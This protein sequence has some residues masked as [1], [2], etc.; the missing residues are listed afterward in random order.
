[1]NLDPPDHETIEGVGRAVRDG[2]RTFVDVVESCLARVEE[3]EPKVK[4]W[5]V[6]DRDRA[7]TQA[8][9]MDRELQWGRDRGAL[10]GIP[11][12]IK[13]IVDVAGLPTSAGARSWSD[14]PARADS[15]IVARLRQLGAVILGKTVT[16]AYA[17]VDPPPTRNPWD[18]GRTPGG[19]SSGSAAALACGMCLAA[20]GT[21]TGG[22]L[23]RPAAFCG[24]ASFKPTDGF[25]I[26]TGIVP[27]APSLDTPGFLARTVRDLERIWGGMLGLRE[28][29]A[30]RT[31]SAAG[32][33]AESLRGAATR[34]LG[35]RSLYYAATSRPEPSPRRF[36]PGAPPV[37]GRVRGFFQDLLEPAVRVI[38][39]AALV[40]LAGAG[41]E[42]VDVELP[43]AFADVHRPH[44]VVMA[45]EA[46]AVHAQRMARIP[47]DY[48]PR[49]RALVEEGLAISAVDYLQA[50]DVRRSLFRAIDWAISEVHALVVPA[51]IGPAPGPETTGDPSF[52][53]P[54]TFA[55]LPT[56]SFP[57]G[58]SGEGL[59]LGIQIVGH[60]F[61][62]P[63]P[64]ARWCE[65]AIRLRRT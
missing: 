29:K 35:S 53:S 16:T 4:A 54:W 9:E 14:G 20:I 28:N 39:E 21:Q 26:S 23:T 2:E 41:A 30:P 58:L 19:S 33:R 64:V 25:L 37:L 40:D 15:V 55:H 12:G 48:P 27:L 49:I 10:H 31:G 52:N 60:R 43:E 44:R 5:V 65:Q 57:I 38:H 62:P 59:P 6:I 45:A 36:H 24:V 22:S 50:L 8:R 32:P 7:L 1:L 11:F 3:Y 51:A 34:D 18:L 13:D 46:A 61:D 47:E 63:F 56:I 42:L 17:W